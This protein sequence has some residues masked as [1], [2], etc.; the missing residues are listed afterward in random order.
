MWALRVILGR[1]LLQVSKLETLANLRDLWV[2]SPQ[3][4]LSGPA[5]R[6]ER[7]SGSALSPPK[8]FWGWLYYCWASPDGSQVHAN[9]MFKWQKSF[10]LHSH[11]LCAVKLDV[12]KL[13][14]PEI[15][16]CNYYLISF[17]DDPIDIVYILLWMQSIFFLALSRTVWSQYAHTDF[18]FFNL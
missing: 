3:G 13:F 10:L 8:S 12:I 4:G 1:I 17:R 15:R 7:C 9:G 5:A 18:F 14:K 16:S 2:Q 6:G 11:L